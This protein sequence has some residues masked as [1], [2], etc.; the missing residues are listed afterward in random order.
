MN[1]NALLTANVPPVAAG[2]FRDAMRQLPGGVSVITAGIGEDRSGMTVT[3]VSSLAIDP[4]SIAH[5][6][7][8]ATRVQVAF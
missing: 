2:A 5:F 3:S 7:A 6:D 4:P 8:L 1:V